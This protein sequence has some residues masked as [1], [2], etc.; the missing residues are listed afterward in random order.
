MTEDRVGFHL[1]LCHVEQLGRCA[2]IDQDGIDV[3]LFGN[4]T[5]CTQAQA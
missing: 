1:G 4:G 2:A 3:L 5:P